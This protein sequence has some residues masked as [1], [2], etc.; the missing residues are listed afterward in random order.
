MGRAAITAV[1]VISTDAIIV[2]LRGE[3]EKQGTRTAT[4][5]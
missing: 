2:L 1:K 5:G 4:T 3:I